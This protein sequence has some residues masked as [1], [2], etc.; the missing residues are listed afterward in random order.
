MRPVRQKV[1]IINTFALAGRIVIRLFL[2]QGECPGL[3]TSA[4]L[5]RVFKIEI[6]IHLLFSTYQLSDLLFE[7][8]VLVVLTTVIQTYDDRHTI[9]YRPPYNRTA[10]VMR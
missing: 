5:G 4:P 2:P 3:Y 7:V 10:V 1:L 8:Y 9:F 6:K